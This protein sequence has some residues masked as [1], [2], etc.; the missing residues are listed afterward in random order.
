MCPAHY[1]TCRSSCQVDVDLFL[2]RLPQIRFLCGLP[3]KVVSME[4]LGRALELLPVA[5]SR[6]RML[7]L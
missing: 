4:T 2:S 3:V 7:A 6:G 5:R 1:G